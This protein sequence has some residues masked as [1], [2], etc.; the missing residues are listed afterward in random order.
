MVP[1]EGKVLVRS[2][3]SLV[4]RGNVKIIQ[5]SLQK[6]FGRPQRW[7]RK[8]LVIQSCTYPSAHGLIRSNIPRASFPC[9]VCMP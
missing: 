1:R 6:P 2:N 8:G 3:G 7:G 9:G 5:I 4:V